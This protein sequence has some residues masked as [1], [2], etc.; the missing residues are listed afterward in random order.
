ML[1]GITIRPVWLENQQVV[2]LEVD[3]RHTRREAGLTSR[4]LVVEHQSQDVVVT[5]ILESGRDWRSFAFAQS[6]KKKEIKRMYDAV[7]PCLRSCESLIWIQVEYLAVSKTYNLDLLQCQLLRVQCFK[8]V[9][10]VFL[11]R[12]EGSHGGQSGIEETERDK[13]NRRDR[14]RTTRERTKNGMMQEV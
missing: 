5:Y 13:A 12:Y 2:G 14:K 11:P 6:E 3:T 8:L 1:C 10:S 9:S 7:A 4:L